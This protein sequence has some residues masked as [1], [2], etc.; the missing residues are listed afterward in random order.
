MSEQEKDQIAIIR[1]L[2]IRRFRGIE[3]LD[4]RPSCGMNVI[5][6]GGDT[7][8]STIL[9]AIA[10]LLSSS[11]A[12]TVAETDYWRRDATT[13]FSITAA[14]S[15]PSSTEVSTQSVFN[16]PWSWDGKEAVSPAAEGDD[17]SESSEPVYKLRVRGTPDLDVVWEV[18]Q[19]EDKPTSLSAS[20][21]R[22]IGLVRLSADDRNDRD[23]RLVFGSALDRL[24]GDPALRARIA[25]QVSEQDLSGPLGAD[26]TKK[27]Q[28]LD[29]LLKDAA[30]PHGI[31]LGLTSSQGLSIGALIGLLA[32]KGGV[33]LPVASWGAGTRRMAALEVASATQSKSRVTVVDEVERGLEPYRLRQL[34]EV[35]ASDHGQSFITTHSAVAIGCTL[36]ATLW[37]LDSAGKIGELPRERIGAQQK[38]DP[39]TFLARLAVIAEGE[40]ELGFLEHL[41]Q[42]SFAEAP[43]H[44]GVRLCLGQGNLQT[45]GLLEAMRSAGLVFAGL[46]DNEGDGSGRWAALKAAMGSRLLQWKS[47][48]EIEVIDAL[49]D[50]QLPELLKNEEG[51]FDGRR[52]R[53]IADRLG[54]SNKTL[55]EIEVALSA[56]KKSLRQLV[57]DAAT[58]SKEGAA[59]NQKKE[60]ESHGRVWFKS[61]DGGEELACKAIRLGAWTTLKSQMMPL[62]NSMRNSCGLGDIPDLLE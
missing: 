46:V 24:I 54:M 21:R 32:D 6:G 42:K 14:I 58:G 60:W 49:K 12:T 29:T 7:G 31:K 61:V 55:A 17:P 57:K 30:L 3:S 2:E 11:N 43:H 35:L 33:L 18:L 37:Y 45:L 27:L 44:Y 9:E 26:G 53:T 41:A 20:M 51:E 28:D 38:R 13:E 23:L 19:P 10:F 39:E 48:T 16:W 56:Q 52:L 34:V 15:L 22:S 8:K 50:E 40:T 62:L 25:K 1:K 5:I 59:E 36:D 47:S 4:W